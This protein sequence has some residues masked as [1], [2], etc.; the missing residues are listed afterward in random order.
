MAVEER[1]VG[2]VDAIEA[3]HAIGELRFVDYKNLTIPW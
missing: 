2:V 1:V 3:D